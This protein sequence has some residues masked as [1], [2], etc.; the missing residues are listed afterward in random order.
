MIEKLFSSR[1]RVGILKL[2]LFNP[3]DSFYQRQ[4]S[5][6]IHQPIRGVQRELERLESI[7]LIERTVQGNRLYYRVNPKSPIFGELRT[8]FFK[9]VGIAEVLKSH[10]GEENDIQIAFIYGSCAKG[11]DSLTSDIDLMIIGSIASKKLSTILS[12]PKGE[13]AREIN[14]VVFSEKEFKKR[15]HTHD[16]FLDSV[17]TE[18]KI[19]IV[20]NEDA[21]GRLAESE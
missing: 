1:T 8:I 4:I 9:T 14:Y 20:G 6:I 11:Q 17:L 21:L 13:L 18:S 5:S 2:F 15:A 3:N 19:N 10:L 16:H 7:G 12:A